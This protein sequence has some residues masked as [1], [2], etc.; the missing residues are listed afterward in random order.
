MGDRQG[1]FS[2][3]TEIA[4]GSNPQSVA[5][6]D[7]NGD[8]HQDIATANYSSSTVS[9]RLGDGQGGF[10]GTTEIVVGSS[11]QSLAVGD[12]NGDGAPDIATANNNT[13]GSVSIRLGDGQGGF[14]GTTEIA[15]GTNPYSVAVGDFNGDGKQDI[16]AANTVSN[17]V[18]IL[19]GGSGEINLQGNL[20]DILSGDNTPD[21]ADDTDFGTVV[22][23]TLST[24]TYT[25]QSTGSSDLIV[26][27]IAISGT[28]AASFA[29]GDIILPATI[30]SGDVATF[31]VTFT[32]ATSGVKTATVTISSDD[33]DEGAYAFNVQGKDDSYTV[34]F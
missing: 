34:F 28:D 11:P 5:V 21:V 3:A 7:F 10:S 12:F 13:S 17:S 31:T 29:L 6:G 20:T 23:N 19:L 9:I 18:S 16:A 22:L 1:G 33:C 24:K 32:A 2:G 30:A 25:I 4:V 8:G 27:A 26:S 15:V 14:S